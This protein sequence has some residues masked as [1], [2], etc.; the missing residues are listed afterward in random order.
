VAS[1]RVVVMEIPPEL[2]QLSDRQVALTKMLRAAQSPAELE[3]AA[4]Q[5]AQRRVRRAWRRCFAAERSAKQARRAAH[6]RASHARTLRRP[7]ATRARRSR[8]TARRAS[9]SPSGSSGSADGPEPSA[10]LIGGAA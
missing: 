8:P 5:T 2:R 3:G 6:L 9:A 7:R 1:A 10:R 4:V